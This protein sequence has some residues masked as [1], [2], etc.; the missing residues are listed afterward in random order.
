MKDLIE[1]VN[2]LTSSNLQ[3]YEENFIDYLDVDDLTL[4][5]YKVG[6][7]NFKE[8]LKANGIKVPT[9]NDI[10]TYRN[11]L[12]ENYE[13]NTVNTYMVALRR[14]FKY[15]KIHNL[16]ED[17]T[18]D[19]KGARYTSTPKK[20][21]LTQE[22]A[23]AIYQS[24]TDKRE[25]A[26]FGLLITTGLRGI[27]VARAKI[28]DIKI[29]NGE[30][31]LWVQCKKHDSKDE[32]VKLSQEVMNDLA[33]YIG[34]RKDGSIFISTSNNNKGKGVATKT[35]RREIK[36][37]FGRFGLTEDTFSLHSTRRTC[38]TIMYN[39]GVP[40]KDIQDILHHKVSTTTQRYINAVTRDNNKG[41]YIA[42][43][44]ILRGGVE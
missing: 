27:E 37:I 25:K 6:I 33:D 20:Q 36:R 44:I 23:T 9:R 16:F 42:S 15:L 14:L 7:E 31:V 17:L 26:L 18:V 4:R 1:N 2:V 13:D 19:I 11:Y 29:H 10:I 41:E 22:Q 3:D 12:R 21:V 8:Y 35:L 30:V 24:L 5:T 39:N 40:L 38:A 32:Y 43:S 28:E 34:D